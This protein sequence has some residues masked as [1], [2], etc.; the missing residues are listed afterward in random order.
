MIIGL[1]LA[2]NAT[3]A[4]I[5]DGDGKLVYWETISSP[6]MLNVYRRIQY[7]AGYIDVICRAFDL[8]EAAIEDYAHAAH[9]RGEAS[10]REQGGVIRN[11]LIELGMPVFL[12]NIS[13]IK[14]FAT[15]DSRAGKDEMFAEFRKVTR[16]R[17]DITEH[18]VDAFFIA[19]VHYYNQNV[20]ESKDRL[21][22]RKIS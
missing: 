20:I 9:A 22:C 12:Y 16:K 10:I 6:L 1:D 21:V 11:R 15:G 2:P 13:T 7:T 17:K 8:T 4:C 19:S 3:G 18:V 14:K 5:L